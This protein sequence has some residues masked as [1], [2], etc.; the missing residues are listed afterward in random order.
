M[1]LSSIAIKML[2]F[3]CAAGLSAVTANVLATKI[4][5]TTEIAVR[6]TLDAR[7]L[8]WAE[9]QSDGLRVLLS[10]TAPDEAARFQSASA[11]GEVVD[12]ARIIDQIEVAP[13]RAVTPPR[14]S[15][16]ILRN[17]SGISAIGLIPAAS[18]R[19]DLVAR[20]T[21]VAGEAGVA[22][23]MESAD[24]PI[25]DGWADAMAFTLKALE[26]LPRSKVSVG[27]GQVSVTAMAPSA[28]ARET[29]ENTL[30]K[31][32]PPGLTVHLALSAPRPVITPFTL[33]YRID[34]GQSGRFEACSADSE[35]TRAHIL[36]AASAAGGADGATCRI[37]LGVPSKGW[38][39]AAAK[40]ITALAELG[41]GSVTF[42][43]ADVT[44][45]AAEGTPPALF[46]KV[47]GELE[48]ALPEVF[49]LHAI[50]PTPP[51][52]SNSGPPEFIATLSPEGQ[53]QLRG[54]L[55]DEGLQTMADAYAKARFGSASVY[56]AARTA[57][58]LPIDWPVRV[59]AGIEALSRL[60][61]GAVIV[62]PEKLDLRGASTNKNA[63]AEIA[64][65]LADRLGEAETFSL[66]IT[67]R[68]P[69]P[70]ANEPKTPEQCEA[71][72]AEVQRSRGKIT[73]EPSSATIDEASLGTMEAIA[74]ILADCGDI[75]L[76][77]QGHTDSQGRTSMNQQLSQERAQSVLNEL[78][79]RRILTSSYAAMGYGEAQP[80][81]DNKTEDGR[82]AN[83]RIEF[84]LI[85]PEPVA[86]EETA[87][88]ALAKPATDE[89]TK[90]AAAAQSDAADP[91]ETSPSEQN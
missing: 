63:G 8:E 90:D 87:L 55:S 38:A 9:V 66:D 74:D 17:D 53:V 76:E 86:E 3:A 36:A 29:L 41:A 69:P 52:N 18:N 40:A 56:S 30:R 19:D 45:A 91:E 68:A 24:H 4:D 6:G 37:G 15:V 7:K 44:L 10:G 35:E 83:R 11:V 28:E 50:L 79:A 1:R 42:A 82:E 85:R 16:E 60:S 75:R 25:P 57:E 14:F 21:R 39:D 77:I 26:K 78:R 64:G 22:D 67:Y 20:L 12:A 47:V 58:G 32:A 46:D 23:L 48:A 73:F 27:A 34:P 51:D 61:N 62:T 43:D 31:A 89:Q 54:R 13:T 49:A 88:E 2:A 70:P 65:L 84:R 80:I 59:L 71:D 81:A 72:I 5:E 33:L